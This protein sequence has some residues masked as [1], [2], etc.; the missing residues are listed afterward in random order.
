MSFITWHIPI[1][2]A[3]CAVCEWR[4]IMFVLE[5]LQS[6][7]AWNVPDSRTHYN[8]VWNI[9]LCCLSI[10]GGKKMVTNCTAGMPQIILHNRGLSQMQ[11]LQHVMDCSHKCSYLLCSPALLCLFILSG[12]PHVSDR[13]QLRGD[14]DQRIQKC[15]SYKIHFLQK[16]KREM[17]HVGWARMRR[18]AQTT[19]LSI[20]PFYPVKLTPINK[21]KKSTFL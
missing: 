20:S 11:K 13:Y 19:S 14:Q 1:P 9:Q 16:K 3:C 15:T 21:K 17:L 5:G 7:H 4:L 12:A 2:L 18:D 6:S 8:R 10:C